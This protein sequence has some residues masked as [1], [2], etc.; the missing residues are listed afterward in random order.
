MEILRV[1]P[2]AQRLLDCLFIF[3][4]VFVHEPL[5]SVQVGLWR[6]RQWIMHTA[7]LLWW[8]SYVVLVSP[9]TPLHSFSFLAATWSLCLIRHFSWF[10]GRKRCLFCHLYQAKA[11]NP[12]YE[13]LWW[14]L[15]RKEKHFSIFKSFFGHELAEIKISV[16]TNMFLHPCRQLKSSLL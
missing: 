3:D 14:S 10:F 5:V 6:L 7:L 11:N 2:T 15:G 13:K 12:S 4:F 8:P 16:I 9:Y 1:F